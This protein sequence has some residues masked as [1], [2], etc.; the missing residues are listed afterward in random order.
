MFIF[1]LQELH[2]VYR[3]QRDLMNEFNMVEIKKSPN[4]TLP[5]LGDVSGNSFSNPH[6]EPKDFFK[7]SLD[8]TDRGLAI[9]NSELRNIRTWNE[10]QFDGQ[11]GKFTYNTP[12]LTL[13]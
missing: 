5:S 1:Q 8:R 3:K 7:S 6:L 13:L 10:R 4:L 12:H 11:A 2:R 9:G